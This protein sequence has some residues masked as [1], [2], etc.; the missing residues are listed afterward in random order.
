MNAPLTPAP[1]HDVEVEQA[2]LGTFLAHPAS[3]EAVIP[4]L[5]VEHLY[6]PLHRSMYR[7]MQELIEAG[8]AISPI[9]LLAR[10]AG[11]PRL[12]DVGGRR[13]FSAL[14][15]A[16]PAYP[17]LLT[18]ASIITEAWVRRQAVDCAEQLI[19]AIPDRNDAPTVALEA[20]QRDLDALQDTWRSKGGSRRAFVSIADL[21]KDV[22]ETAEAAIAADRPPGLPTG[23]VKVDE[24]LGGWHPTDLVLIPGRP[25][26]FKS[27]TLTNF[28]LSAVKRDIPSIFFSYEMAALQLGQRLACDADFNNR[29]GESPMAYTWFRNGKA[30]PSDIER[31][32]QVMLDLQGRPGVVVDDDTLTAAELAARARSFASKYPGR[33]GLIFVD[34][35]QIMPPPGH[36]GERSREWEVSQNARSLKALAK[37][38]GWT[39]VAAAQVN[40]KPEQRAESEKRPQLSDLRESGQLEAE[41]D[42]IAFPYRPGYYVEN[43]RPANKFDAGWSAWV[44][45]WLSVRN[46]FEL[47][48][49]KN[50]HGPK[51]NLGL[52]CD[53]RPGVIRD[54][55]PP[56]MRDDQMDDTLLL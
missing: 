23:L 54:E 24:V 47:L 51:T 15:S 45:E 8:R 56:D 9:S 41:A 42:V 13:Y 50:R 25:G 20:A 21:T 43:K 5:P 34:Y 10:L 12:K 4:V 28:Y 11:D 46:D 1:L 26:M 2:L 16:A 53:M 3:I 22:V 31:V 37:R 38:L 18:F 7:A 36:S 52:W 27:G 6:D 30:K 17:N 39:V 33:Q 14:A 55:C 44:N 35:V 32:A 29:T 40:R 19:A 48:I 49:Q